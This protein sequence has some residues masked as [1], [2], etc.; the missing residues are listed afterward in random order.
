MSDWAAKRF[1]SDVTVDLRGEGYVILLDKRLV[2]TPAKATLA[3]PSQAMAEAIA[4]EWEAQGGKI[5]PRTMTPQRAEVAQLIAAYGED[6]LLC[7]RAPS[8]EELLTRQKEAWDPLLAWAAEHLDAPL[9][10]V[11][12]VMHVAQPANAV[13]NLTA[14]VVTQSP[15]QLAALHDLVSMSGSLVIGLA[16][17][18]EAFAIDDL[19]TR[20]RL[21]ELW[22]IEQWGQDDEADATASLKR[23]AFIHA[24]RFYKM[25]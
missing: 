18:A 13:A 19:W 16:A 7:Y 3:V 22:Q 8:P 17:Q 9:R 1:W 14:R 4:A 20:S 21:D 15:F 12:G 25:S 6:D 10:T 2:K 11:E 5:D 23:S 24:H